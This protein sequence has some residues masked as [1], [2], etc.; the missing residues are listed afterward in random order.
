MEASHLQSSGA[1][2]EGLGHHV[3]LYLP[4]ARADLADTPGPHVSSVVHA[5]EPK[6][7]TFRSVVMYP[8]NQGLVFY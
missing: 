2:I 6:H 3:F 4:Q 7:L 1:Q 5:R 8:T